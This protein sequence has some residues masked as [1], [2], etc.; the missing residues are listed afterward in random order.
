MKIKSSILRLLR[1]FSSSKEIVVVARSEI[2]F[3]CM[4]DY[5]NG[6]ADK[7]V[8]DLVKESREMG[9][10]ITKEVA[11]KFLAGLDQESEYND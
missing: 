5:R 11:K 7:A 3:R 2:I 10:I 4:E 8:N 6:K 1:W 9:S